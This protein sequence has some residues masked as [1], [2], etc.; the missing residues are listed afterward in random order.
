[1]DSQRIQRANDAFD[2]LKAR[3]FK[4]ATDDEIREASRGVYYDE[5]AAKE[6]IPKLLQIL[7]QAA[8]EKQTLG[9]HP[10]S[11]TAHQNYGAAKHGVRIKDVQALNAGDTLE[12]IVFCRNVGDAAH[13]TEPGHCWDTLLDG[14]KATTPYSPATY[15][16]IEGM[17][18]TLDLTNG[19]VHDKFEW[20]VNATSAPIES[21]RTYWS[22]LNY[23]YP[24][25]FQQD[26]PAEDVLTWDMF[27]PNTRVGWRGPMV[28]V[29]D[30]PKFPVQRVTHYGNFWND[31]GVVEHMDWTGCK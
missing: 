7:R 6:P 24:E 5:R 2:V 14:L 9:I 18:G 21:R 13:G 12:L 28:R 30:L 11:V 22:P 20:E 17:R 8:E 29:S 31:Y 23:R 26:H 10:D 25:G 1:M 27:D 16:H 3:D 15:T 19:G 4:N